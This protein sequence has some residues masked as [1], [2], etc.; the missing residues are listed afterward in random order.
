MIIAEWKMRD[1]EF[2]LQI[3]SIISR[4]GWR[5]ALFW[6]IIIVTVLYSGEEQQFIYFQ[7]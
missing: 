1:K 6:I 4:K 2:P 7:F 5:I 3:D